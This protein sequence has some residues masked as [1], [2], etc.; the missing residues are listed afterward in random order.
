MKLLYVLLF[1]LLLVSASCNDD[2]SSV[3]PPS[4]LGENPPVNVR[5]L[6]LGDS[7][8]IGEGVTEKNRWPALL[9]ERL[10]DDNIQ[11]SKLQYVAQSGWTTSQLIEALGSADLT[12]GYELVS[13]LIGVNNQF[14]QQNMEA[15]KAELGFLIDFSITLVANDSSRVLLLSIPDYSVTPYAQAIYGNTERIAEEITVFNRAIKELAAE[16]NIPYINITDLSRF[17]KNDSSYLAEDQLHL[18]AKMYALWAGRVE[19]TVLSLFKN[20]SP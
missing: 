8:T 7:Y 3:I 12:N 11:V 20:S 4:I 15:F 9:A 5:Y 14:R 17:A 13:I 16:K 18:S 1:T 10:R 6:A 19:H 2:D